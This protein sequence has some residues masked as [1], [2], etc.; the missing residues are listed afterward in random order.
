[1]A[2][3]RFLKTL[4]AKLGFKKNNAIRLTDLWAYSDS[5][6]N[7]RSAPGN[8][9]Q[10]QTFL[11]S[12]GTEK[13]LAE[14]WVLYLR[15]VPVAARKNYPALWSDYQQQT[16]EWYYKENLE[17]LEPAF[18]SQVK[19]FQ[20]ANLLFQAME[21]KVWSAAAADT[22]GQLS[23]YVAHKDRY[24]WTDGAQVLSVASPDS[25]IGAAFKNQ[26][27]LNPGQWRAIAAAFN[28]SVI[29]DSARLEISQLPVERFE[30]GVQAGAASQLFKNELDGSVSFSLV[31]SKQSGGDFRTFQEARG[32]V[33]TDFQNLLENQWLEQL[34]TK[35]PVKLN[36]VVWQQ[37]LKVN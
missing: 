13:V 16:A 1:M 28:E 10:K 24:R 2:R 21:T 17:Q 30:N 29:V 34:K 5:A 37:L 27:L 31:L 36:E 6:L 26:L 33:I 19:E 11:F 20:D 18:A 9:I 15:G 32:W 22:A 4:P 7:N 3:E 12:V 35:Y 23:Y 14:N 25:A 8:P